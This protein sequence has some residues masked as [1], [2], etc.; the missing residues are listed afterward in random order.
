MGRGTMKRW[1]FCLLAAA[2]AVQ[3]F[4]E[5]VT[6]APQTTG[7]ALTLYDRGMGMVRERRNV[8]LMSGEN[9]VVMPGI[10]SR[11]DPASVFFT[12]P[13]SVMGVGTVDLQFRHDL[14]DQHLFLAQ[15]YSRVV[16]VGTAEQL[17]TGVLLNVME[18]D[19]GIEALALQM[20]GGG[21]STIQWRDVQRVE[22]PGQSESVYTAPTLLWRVN[23]QKDQLQNVR[24][25][26]AAA[27][28]TWNAEYTLILSER[29]GDAQ[30]SGKLRL[31]NGS[32]GAFQE[33]SIRL[34]STEKGV[35]DLLRGDA[36]GL[37]Y[38][39]E[40]QPRHYHFGS[41][42]LRSEQAFDGLDPIFMYTCA[43]P[44]SLA[45]GEE[46]LV[47]YMDA[48]RLPIIQQ[49]VYDGVVFDRYQ[50]N[51][52]NDWNYGTESRRAVELF[53]SFQN[54]KDAGLSGEPLAPGR[55]RLFQRLADG[56]VDYLGDTVAGVVSTGQTA[57]IKLGV[58]RDLSGWRERIGY[59]E[60]VPLHE[61]EET[62]E[63]RLQN[64]QT[65]DVV[66]T[67]VEHMYRWSNFEIVKADTEYERQGEE[68]IVFKPLIKAGG[69]RT[70]R[71]TV[72][73]RW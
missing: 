19:Q 38:G 43:Q 69:N 29:R 5:Q 1:M 39:T 17:F 21:I 51:R 3:V 56:G 58:A 72:R 65:E 36:D 18:S 73:Y 64:N 2:S 7:A 57:T 41:S 37:H 26:Y 32:G 42:L 54:G 70:L 6:R 15:G 23:S 61:Y 71:Y 31:Q 46:R 22:I 40:P 13:A 55:Y 12:P 68:V 67:V 47:Q 10:P 34:V 50:R 35:A 66:I 53:I 28:L 59:T 25:N 20:E 52:R 48:E 63:I 9:L 45:D 44:V 14:A 16:A 30:L 33:A 49:Y 60:V 24:L 8:N 27:G 62:F 4:G 11:L